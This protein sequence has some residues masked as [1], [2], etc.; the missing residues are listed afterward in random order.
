MKNPVTCV[1]GPLYWL[2]KLS[3]CSVGFYTAPHYQS[4][5]AFKNKM[6]IVTMSGVAFN[7]S[8]LSIP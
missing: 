1:S 3:S 2:Q 6:L 5:I 7:L 4:D 8:P